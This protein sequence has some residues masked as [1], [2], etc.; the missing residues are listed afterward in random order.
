MASKYSLILFTR[1]TRINPRSISITDVRIMLIAKYA[2]LKSIP[3]KMFNS[4]T[5]I[6]ADIIDRIVSEVIFDKQKIIAL[7]EK[8]FYSYL[9]QPEL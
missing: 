5:N 3:P 8:L 2:M 4:T 6:V 1:E 9:E 7:Y